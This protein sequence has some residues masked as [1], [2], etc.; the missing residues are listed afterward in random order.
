MQAKRKSPVLVSAGLLTAAALLAACGT[1]GTAPKP[2]APAGSLLSEEGTA[3]PATL[4]A[5]TPAAL[6]ALPEAAPAPVDAATAKAAWKDGVAAFENGDYGTAVDTLKVAVAG[7]SDD[8]YARYLLGLSEWKNGDPAAAAL[9][10]EDSLK[11]DANRKKT[12]INLA[13]VRMAVDDAKGA[14]DA[15]GHALAIDPDSSDGYHLEGRALMAENRADEAEV[16]LRKAV[17]LDPKNGYAANT[18]GLL[19]IQRGRAAD[20][21]PFLETAKAELSHVPYVRNNL[22]VAYERTGRL[23]D[24]LV[25]YQAAVDAGDTGNA[26]ASLT[27]LGPLVPKD[28]PAVASNE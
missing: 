3:I 13:R 16:A 8:A 19:L 17:Q 27:R 10:F 7:R 11:L 6:P 12:W 9:S 26:L 25:E 18:L 1:G 14:L 23:A 4:P 20:A 15:A 24:A 21:I 22:G 2:A 28:A 5:A